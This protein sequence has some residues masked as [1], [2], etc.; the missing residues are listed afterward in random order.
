MHS[1]ASETAALKHCFVDL[2][3]NYKNSDIEEE[4]NVDKGNNNMNVFLFF[5]CNCKQLLLFSTFF[6][7]I[8]KINVKVIQKYYQAGS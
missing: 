5:F 7:S 1:R 6:N 4:V 8:L 3:S 2:F